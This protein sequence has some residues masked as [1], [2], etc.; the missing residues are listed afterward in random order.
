VLSS[1]YVNFLLVLYVTYC[2]LIVNDLNT[3]HV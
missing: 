1:F 3:V 2:R